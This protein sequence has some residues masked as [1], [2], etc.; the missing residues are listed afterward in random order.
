MILISD[1][2]ILFSLLTKLIN[3]YIITGKFHDCLK[4][5]ALIIPIFTK[6]DYKLSNNYRPISLLPVF[7]RV[8]E[9]DIGYSNTKT[10]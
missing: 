2:N 6:S 9:N 1:I 3:K 4:K 10:L 5:N 8:L 7:S